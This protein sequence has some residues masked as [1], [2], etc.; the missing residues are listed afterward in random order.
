MS[1][2]DCGRALIRVRRTH[3]K[4]RGTVFGLGESFLRV[5]VRQPNHLTRVIECKLAREE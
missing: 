1:L 3:F 5:R 4:I 2:F